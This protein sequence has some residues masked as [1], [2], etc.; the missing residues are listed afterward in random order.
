MYCTRRRWYSGEVRYLLVLLAALAASAA[1]AR[2]QVL[3]RNPSLPAEEVAVYSEKVG[4]DSWTV[5]QTLSL[6]SEKGDSFYEFTSSSPESDVSMRLDAATLFPRDS[7]VITRSGDSVIRR[8]TEILK[9]AP[10]PKADELVIGDFNSLAVTLRG[11]PWG[12]FSTLNLVALGTGSR[13]RQFSFQLT[14]AGRESVSAGGKTYDCFKVQLGIG[15]FMGAFVGKSTY[16]FFADAP[17]FLVKSEGPT[18]GP[19]SP[20]QRSEL[21]TYSARGS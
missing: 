7:Q 17:H 2:G 8:T 13:G 16:W 19:G 1:P 9:A 12:N 21:Q 20:I 4:S 5:T 3:I 18:G 10:H 15:G 6:R 14:A 11:L